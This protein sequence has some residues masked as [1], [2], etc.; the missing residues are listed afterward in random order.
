VKSD[1]VRQV[2]MLIYPGV[3]IGQLTGMAEVFRFANELAHFLQPTAPARYQLSYFQLGGQSSYRM[4]GVQIDCA[5]QLPEH[6]DAL[7]IPGSYAHHVSELTAQISFFQQHREWFYQLERQGCLIAAA[8]NGSFGLAATG[9]LDQQQA[10]TCWF[11]AEFF[12]QQFP[13]VTLDATATVKRAGYCYTAG[14]TTAYLSLCLALVQQFD[15]VRF[16]AQLAKI[17]LVEPALHGQAP[18]LSVD[19]L[20]QHNDA[21]IAEVQVYLRNHLAEPLDLQQLSV[22]FAMSSRT[23]IRRF[24]AA[25]GETPMAWLQKLRIDKAKMLLESS[26]ISIEQLTRAIGYEDVSSF[27][28]L[29]QQFTRL[30]PKAYRNQFSL[31]P[32]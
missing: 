30:T 18:F 11:L 17:L 21:R 4:D 32:I 25:T 19:Q 5:E 29:F 22:R 14:A 26:N 27:R 13:A 2:V 20:V 7:L 15:G 16:A 12:Q 10:T 31:N 3:T 28:K 8:C 1:M 6:I 24:K 9:L 23:L